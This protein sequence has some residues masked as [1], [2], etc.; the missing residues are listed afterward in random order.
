MFPSTRWPLS[1]R[2]TSLDP[3]ALRQGI[4]V[5]MPRTF[6]SLCVAMSV[7]AAFPA[8]AFAYQDDVNLPDALVSA[9]PADNTPNVMPDFFVIIA[10]TRGRSSPD[11]GPSTT[12]TS[13]LWI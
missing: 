1:G 3:A 9:N 10:S 8:A 13:G 2:E 11:H 12:S 6:T 7:L 4:T 5:R